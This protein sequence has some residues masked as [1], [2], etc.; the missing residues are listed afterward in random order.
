MKTY[1]EIL[2]EDRRSAMLKLL[3]ESGGSA[4]ERILYTALESL[5]HRLVTEENVR[6]D[7]RFL[8]KAGAIRIEYF[9]ERI[10]VAHI[11]IRGTEIAAGKTIVEGIKRP[12]IGE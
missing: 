1:P 4:N 8:E 10:A 12:T 3:V 6:A 2:A 11:L 5:G 9:Q 7:L